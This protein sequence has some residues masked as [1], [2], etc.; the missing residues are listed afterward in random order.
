MAGQTRSR[1]IVERT[2]LTGSAAVGIWPCNNAEGFRGGLA[3]PAD[4]TS[5]ICKNRRPAPAPSKHAR[6]GPLGVSDHAPFQLTDS[7]RY[8]HHRDHVT[9]VATEAGL[10][11]STL[12]E[13]VLRYEYGHPVIGLIV[14]LR[15]QP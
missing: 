7:G 12:D 4:S 2:H 15:S 10:E 9:E 8:T 1:S 14:V 13:V 5:L 3:G 11:V 6:P